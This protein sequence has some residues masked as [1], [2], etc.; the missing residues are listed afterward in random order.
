MVAANV[1]QGRSVSAQLDYDFLKHG[2]NCRRGNS[3]NCHSWLASRRRCALL[4]RLAFSR[5]RTSLI[6]EIIY[7]A[8]IIG[9]ILPISL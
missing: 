3:F 4:A 8:N 7:F 2:K 6:H 1:N 5:S 9:I